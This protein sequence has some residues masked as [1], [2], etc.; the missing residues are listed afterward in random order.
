MQPGDALTAALP[1]I[2]AFDRLG[3]PYLE[4]WAAEL[5]VADLLKRAWQDAGL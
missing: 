1:V 2:A 3:V 5:G 4:N